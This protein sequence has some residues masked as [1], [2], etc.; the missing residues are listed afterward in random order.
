[1]INRSGFAYMNI[2]AE[3]LLHRHP[4]AGEYL[5]H[6]QSCPPHPETQCLSTEEANSL[7]SWPYIIFKYTHQLNNRQ[8]IMELTLHYI[9]T[10]IPFE[11]K[12]TLYCVLI[13]YVIFKDTYHLSSRQT[14]TEFTSHNVKKKPPAEWTLLNV[15]KYLL[16]AGK[17]IHKLFVI[18]G[19]QYTCISH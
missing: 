8:T 16:T 13:H 17:T 15:Q 12:E 2:P 19:E 4:A 14:I 10:H 9:Q 18:F 11:Q 1:M 6:C 7:H 5:A 3:L